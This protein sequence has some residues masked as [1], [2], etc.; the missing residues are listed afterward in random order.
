MEEFNLAMGVIYSIAEELE[1]LFNSEW[2]SVFP[3]SIYQ[4]LITNSKNEE[5]ITTVM[6]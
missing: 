5:K 6:I 1:Q 2:D 4:L 3:I